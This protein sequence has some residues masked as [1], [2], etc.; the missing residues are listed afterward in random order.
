MPRPNHD[1]IA[2]LKR[3]VLASRRRFEIRR[4]HRFQGLL[5]SHV[6]RL[7]RYEQLVRRIVMDGAAEFIEVI[8]YVEMRTRVF[9]EE[10][11]VGLVRQ[12]A[13]VEGCSE[14]V[15]GTSP[16]CWFRTH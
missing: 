4:A 12:F 14:L 1:S 5:V 9:G 7:R 13:L 8:G 16:E 15:I 6:E 11:G 3:D 10:Q 2:G